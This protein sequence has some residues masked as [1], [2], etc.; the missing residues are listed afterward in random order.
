MQPVLQSSSHVTQ[1]KLYTHSTSLLGLHN[2]NTTEFC[3]SPGGLKSKIKGCAG[4]ISSDV[5]LLGLQMLYLAVSSPM[6][7]CVRA[8]LVPVGPDCFSQG[9]QSDWLHSL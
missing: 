9:H 5:S 7:P 4:L 6:L 2:K 8:S 1:L 3:H